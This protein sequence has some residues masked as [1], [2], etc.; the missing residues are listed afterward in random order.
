[1]LLTNVVVFSFSKSAGH[2]LIFTCFND[3]VNPVLKESKELRSK[4]DTSPFSVF[5]TENVIFHGFFPSSSFT[6]SHVV[7]LIV[8]ADDWYC[9]L[10]STVYSRV[11]KKAP[12]LSFVASTDS[13]TTLYLP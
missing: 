6:A 12:S 4:P 11:G 9:F 1:M 13:N 5:Q 10:H 7:S 2:F 3:Q 8:S